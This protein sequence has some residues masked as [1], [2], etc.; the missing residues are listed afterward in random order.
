MSL[1]IRILLRSSYISDYDLVPEG[2]GIQNKEYT[3]L[4][5]DCSKRELYHSLWGYEKSSRGNIFKAFSAWHR[6][7]PY[8]SV[9]YPYP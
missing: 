3:N 9:T 7:D 2:Q 8:K 1:Q 4:G 5:N 6:I